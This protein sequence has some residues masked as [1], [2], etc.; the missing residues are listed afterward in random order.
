MIL[1][2]YIYNRYVENILNILI[3]SQDSMPLRC[4]ISVFYKL[5]I[6]IALIY[7]EACNNIKNNVHI[8]HNIIVG[9]KKQSVFA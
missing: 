2:K 1:Y 6:F 8:I 9:K 4:E 5:G 7:G 3:S